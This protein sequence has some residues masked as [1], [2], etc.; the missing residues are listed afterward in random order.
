MDSQHQKWAF[1]ALR[2]GLTEYDMRHGYRGPE[3]FIDLKNLSAND[4]D[5]ALEVINAA[6]EDYS[7][8]FDNLGK[9]LVLDD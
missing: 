1:D 8:R 7:N 9:M 6:I 3:S 5:E 4:R 2:A